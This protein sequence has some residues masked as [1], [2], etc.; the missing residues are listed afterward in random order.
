MTSYDIQLRLL[1]NPIQS[2]LP[3]LTQT[4]AWRGLQ[5][6]AY[7]LD[8][9]LELGVGGDGGPEVDH[10][11]PPLLAPRERPRH[12]RHQPQPHQ[13]RDDRHENVPV[14]ILLIRK[15]RAPL[16]RVFVP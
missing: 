10:Q 16:D 5:G 14:R 3:G 1:S 9:G 8:G 15:D 7:L 4:G 2:R 11:I 13:Q 6:R 12:Q